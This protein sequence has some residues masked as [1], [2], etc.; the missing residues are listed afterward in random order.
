M[1]SQGQPAAGQR[2]HGQ[3]LRR[4]RGGM[5]RVGGHDGGP[6][7]DARQLGAGDRQHGQRVG[8]EDLGQPDTARA[9]LGQRP[10]L[11][12]LVARGTAPAGDV[13]DPDADSH[14]GRR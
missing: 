14:G 8:T 6:E 10:D 12:D 2:L 13:P 4:Q 3:R 11:L 9:A 7:L 5:A 1:S